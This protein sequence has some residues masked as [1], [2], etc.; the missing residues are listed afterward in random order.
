MWHNLSFAAVM[1]DTLRVKSMYINGSHFF[2]GTHVHGCDVFFKCL[3]TRPHQTLDT[4]V[5]VHIVS[6]LLEGVR[7]GQVL[8]FQYDEKSIQSL[9]VRKHTVNM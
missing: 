4:R 3:I 7:K 8:C 2:I 5:P 1:V 6:I 9:H